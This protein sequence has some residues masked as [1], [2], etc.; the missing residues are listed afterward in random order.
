MSRKIYKNTFLMSLATYCLAGVLLL[1]AAGLL[2]C[3]SVDGAEG[4]YYL[5]Q[6]VVLAI[7][8][9]HTWLEDLVFSGGAYGTD[10][11]GWLITLAI[12]LAGGI[13]AL[14]VY[15]FFRLDYVFISCIILFPLPW[16]W[17]LT[18]RYF[19]AIPPAF[20]R[21]WHY[22]LEEETPDLDLID[23]SQIEVL[24]FV[25]EKRSSEHRKF[26]FT[27]KA[28]LH[29]ELGQL[30]LL[31]INDYNEKNSL[32]PIEYLDA[33][34]ISQGWLF[35]RKRGWFRRR[36]YFDPSLSFRD[37][38]VL[39]NELIYAIRAGAGENKKAGN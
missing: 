20:Y 11:A 13:A 24:Q 1:T 8:V 37:N 33:N 18:Y 25:L 34:R 26:N 9:L 19:R 29:M 28:P 10:R 32:Y 17:R 4:Y 7:G 39:P 35:Y 12:W 22:P 27:A 15:H 2:P 31:F 30:F 3:I 38:G 6:L 23:L 14:V 16:V 36:H 21:R 5:A